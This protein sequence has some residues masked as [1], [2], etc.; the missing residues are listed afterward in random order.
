[1]KKNLTPTGQQRIYGAG[2]IKRMLERQKVDPT[3]DAHTSIADKPHKGS[4]EQERRL[5]QEARKVNP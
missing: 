4:R 3:R 1:M 5:R 2:N